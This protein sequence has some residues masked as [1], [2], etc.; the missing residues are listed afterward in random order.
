MK[1]VLY[2]CLSLLLGWSLTGT[3][4]MAAG[5]QQQSKQETFSNPA[6]ED[7]DEF[8]QALTKGRVLMHDG[9]VDAAVKEFRKAAA[10]KNGQ[11][12]ECFHLIGQ[13][14]YGSGKYKD[15]AVPISRSSRSSRQ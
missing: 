1:T 14:Y 6:M 11:C 8:H 7:Q 9:D 15:A 10:L 3:V 12:A 2:L 4:Q 5:Q 13:S